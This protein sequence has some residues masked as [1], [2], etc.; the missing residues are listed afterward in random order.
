[1][2]VLID[3]VNGVTTVCSWRGVNPTPVTAGA[4]RT[5]DLHF[6]IFHNAAK[7]FSD[8]TRAHRKWGQ[9]WQRFWRAMRALPLLFPADHVAPSSVYLLPPTRW[10]IARLG[11]YMYVYTPSRSDMSREATYNNNNDDVCGPYRPKLFVT[12][13]LGLGKTMHGKKRPHC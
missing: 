10:N 3:I 4:R 8:P 1:M 7:N 2:V 12:L 5:R 6:S 9:V 13:S 11:I